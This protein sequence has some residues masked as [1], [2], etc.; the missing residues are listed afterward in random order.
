MNSPDRI[1]P[2]NA[3]C[4][5]CGGEA[6]EF[7]NLGRQPLSDNFLTAQELSSE[8]F[9]NLRAVFCGSCSLA[10]LAETPPRERMFNNDY[11]Y[12]SSGSSVMREHFQQT[13]FE[14]LET[15]LA[16]RD[17]FIIEIGC[18]DGVML[19]TICDA[20]V[21]HLGFEP[22]GKVASAAREKGIRVRGDFFEEA[23]A[24]ETREMEGA[25]DV[26][27]SANTICHIPYIESIIKGVDSLLAPG[28]I[29]VFEDPYLGDI[30]SK[31]SFD[32]IY[33]EH[34]FLFSGRSVQAIADRFGFALVD[35]RRLSVHGGEIRY[36]LARKGEREPVAAV[37][38]LIAEEDR[39]S[40]TEEETLRQFAA[41]V[42]GIRDDL[43]ALLR[44]LR[45]EGR[46]VVGYGAT[47]KSS[48]VTNFCGIGSDLVS[49]VC[50]TTPAKQNRLTPGM[51]LQVRP[52]EDFSDPYPDYAL[53][54]AWNHAD[55][56]MAKEEQFRLA[57]GRWITYVPKVQVI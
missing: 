2:G 43:I 17:P 42:N 19:K 31:T 15:E 33:D 5:V 11:P 28:G 34:T 21:R 47:A 37:A 51:H 16:G 14:F 57:G 24:A 40:L 32:Q 29:F 7:L 46:T 1:A 38:A 45:S 9:Y 8:F 25:A 53:L 12:Y 6:R 54:F 3:K 35:V 13:A 26:I 41:R 4:N 56:I 49:Y 39:R 48:T 50:D 52:G 22:S 36:T 10:Q 20:G 30:I 23:T 55:E 18:N 44:R 27:F